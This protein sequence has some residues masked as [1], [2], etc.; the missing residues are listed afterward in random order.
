VKLLE[1]A[2]Y[3]AI[4]KNDKI[5]VTIPFYR[6]DILHPVDLI[7]DIA[8][9]YGYN[10][11]VPQELSLFTEG[12]ILESTKKENK[13]AAVLTGL[14]FQELA[15]LTLSNKEEQFKKMNL[16][17]E[18]IIEIENP[19]SLSYSC[20]RKWLIPSLM[21]VLSQNTTKS[22]PQKIF[23]T[24]DVTRTDEKS[25]VKSD[26][27]QKLAVAIANKDANF[28][29]IK[30]VL[31]YL[32]KNLKFE[33]SLKPTVHPSLIEGRA[34]EI[35]KDKEKI[36]IIGEINPKVLSN[37]GLDVPVSVLEIDASKL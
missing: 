2:R 16:P 32:S 3:S 15:T 24:G 23:E 14:E 12:S 9:A 36:G 11:I 29:E 28:T 10:K 20:L 27:V 21:G 8:I 34:A 5:E 6:T 22:Y 4:I 1:K 35:I 7:E 33:F 25:E 26:T 19:V 18:E 31:D 30:Q 37:W 13:I 17:S